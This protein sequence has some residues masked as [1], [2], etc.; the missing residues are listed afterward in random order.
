MNDLIIESLVLEGL[1][2]GLIDAWRIVVSEDIASPDVRL[3]HPT[4]RDWML[5]LSFLTEEQRNRV[6]EG[7]HRIDSG[8]Y[9][10]H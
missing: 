6:R 2:D 7:L 3:L 1:E 10:V 8:S 5:V 9:S 4:S